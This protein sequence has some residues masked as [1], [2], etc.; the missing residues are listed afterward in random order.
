VFTS[1]VMQCLLVVVLWAGLA[2]FSWHNARR[3]R[4]D[5]PPK[6]PHQQH[7]NQPP[8]DHP[9]KPKQQEQIGPHFQ[10]WISLLLD[11]HKAQCYFGG[12]LMLAVLASDLFSTSFVTTFLVTPLATNSILPLI[13]SYLLL[14]YF[15]ASTPATAILTTVVY[16]LASLVYWV[17]YIRL[18]LPDGMTRDGMYKRYRLGVSSLEACG[19]FSGLA[20]CPEGDADRDEFAEGIGARLLLRVVTPIIWTWATG[21]L[22]VL[23]LLPVFRRSGRRSRQGK[24]MERELAE[25]GKQGDEN[26]ARSTGDTTRTWHRVVFWLSTVVFVLGVGMQGSVLATAIRLD[27]VDIHGWSFGQIVAVTVWV[28]PLLEYFC[29][30]MSGWHR[31]RMGKWGGEYEEVPMR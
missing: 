3:G 22:G 25:S 19:E 4:P 21:V 15:R 12:T 28:P 31:R 24:K 10:A 30:E 23:L 7:P 11:S 9:D 5:R 2:G 13:F 14:V 26:T 20:V 27:M 18:R 6:E 29:G 17:L 1:Y 16:V 8:H